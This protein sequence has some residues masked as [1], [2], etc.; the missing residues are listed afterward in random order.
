MDNGDA[1]ESD[2]LLVPQ[3]HTE[4]QEIHRHRRV[5]LHAFFCLFVLGKF[6]AACWILS[7]NIPSIVHAIYD[8]VLGANL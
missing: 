8:G 4:A 1:I 2:V 5:W 6:L 7:S 3:Q